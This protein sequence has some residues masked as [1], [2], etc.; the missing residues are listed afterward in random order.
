MRWSKG[1]V[2]DFE[3]AHEKWQPHKTTGVVLDWE[4]DPLKIYEMLN[5]V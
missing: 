5:Q 4:A 3:V 1:R 2:K